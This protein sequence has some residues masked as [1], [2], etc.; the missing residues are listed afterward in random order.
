MKLPK[1]IWV[2]GIRLTIGWFDEDVWI[3]G[4][5]GYSAPEEGWIKLSPNLDERFLRGVLLHEIVHAIDRVLF[6]KDNSMVIRIKDELKADFALEEE[7]VLAFS[8]I[9]FSVLADPRNREAVDWMFGESFWRKLWKKWMFLACRLT[10][11]R[12]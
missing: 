1:E 7:Q 3:N 10:S 8:Q 12:K 11:R 5:V 9:L 6:T 4:A 2:L